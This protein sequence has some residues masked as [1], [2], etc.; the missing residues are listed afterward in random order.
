MTVPMD[1]MQVQDGAQMVVMELMQV[2]HVVLLIVRT[3]AVRGGVVV[4]VLVGHLGQDLGLVNQVAQ[5]GTEV[6]EV[7]VVKEVMV[8]EVIAFQGKMGSRVS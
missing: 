3:M 6:G 8:I 1:R 4:P 5:V 2:G 7:T